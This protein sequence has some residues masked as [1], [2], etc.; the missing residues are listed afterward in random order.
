MGKNDSKLGR[1]QCHMVI[2]MHW[3]HCASS[4]I[5]HPLYSILSIFGGPFLFHT[6]LPNLSISLPFLAMSSATITNK[7]ES[8]TAHP[9][10][11]FHSSMDYQQFESSVIQP[12][13][14]QAKLCDSVNVHH[15]TSLSFAPAPGRPSLDGLIKLL[16]E[17]DYNNTTSMMPFP[18]SSCSDVSSARVEGYF[19]Q[20]HLDYFIWES[21]YFEEG[22]VVLLGGSSHLVKI[23]RVY[24]V[25]QNFFKMSVKEL[26]DALK[27][28]TTTQRMI[29]SFAPTTSFH[30]TFF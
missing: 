7:S 23:L 5:S 13:L 19:S 20:A 24:G 26:G 4:T 30:L 28:E 10:E 25:G 29:I 9:L 22:S 8:N 12:F 3:Q 14:L 21:G 27:G 16:S 15:R 17:T 6:S 18:A 1:C 2:V 11:S